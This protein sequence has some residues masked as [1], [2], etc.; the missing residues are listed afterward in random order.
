MAHRTPGCST[1]RV[2]SHRILGGSP[3]GVMAHRTLGCSEGGAADGILGCSTGGVMAHRTLG[4]STG[5]AMVHIALGCCC[6]TQNSRLFHTVVP[7]VVSWTEFQ[8]VSQRGSWHTERSAVPHV[9][10]WHTEPWLNLYE[11]KRILLPLNETERHLLMLS[12][13]VNQR[14]P[15]RFL[16]R[17]K[18]ASSSL[19]LN[20]TERVSSAVAVCV[21][22]ERA[23]STLPYVGQR[24]PFLALSVPLSFSFALS[25][26]DRL[27]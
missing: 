27:F 23:A 22:T 25:A 6:G 14:G 26:A 18:E 10:P 11:A 7:Q 19:R 24:G 9:V 16:V 15:F 5:G 13:R 1:C 3:C 12:R 21:E 4:C 8:V 2:M 17:V 20:E